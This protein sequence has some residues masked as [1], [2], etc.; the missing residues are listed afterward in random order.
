LDSVLHNYAIKIGVEIL[1]VIDKRI[2]LELD[3]NCRITYQDLA[4]IVN[5]SANA[6]KKRVARLLE[7]GVIERFIAILSLEMIN[8]DMVVGLVHTDGSEFQEQFINEISQHD[9]VIQVSPVACGMG[10]LYCVFAIVI[11][12]SGLSELG[13]FLRGLDSVDQVNLHVIIYPR[14]R[15]SEFTP[16]QLR[17]IKHLI[18]EPRMP[19]VEIAKLSGLTSRRVRKIL[20]EL[21]K[22]EAISL[23]ILWNLGAEGLTDAFVRIEWDEKKTTH[24]EISNWLSQEFPLEY[25]S[26]FVSAMSPVLFA[27]FVFEKLERIEFISRKIREADFTNSISTLVIY[28]NYLCT[29]PSEIKLREMVENI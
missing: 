16:L 8:A 27:R 14:G 4:D 1:D 17:V 25:W 19:V 3:S 9:D 10:G 12:S 23:A 26:P 5:L 13:S 28:S 24:K 2:L 11:G 15:K 6:V 22:E 29:W 7:I 20:D 18:D 21:Q